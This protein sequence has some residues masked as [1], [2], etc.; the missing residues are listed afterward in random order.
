MKRYL[1]TG[2][3][4][5]IGANFLKYL[6][7]KYEEDIYV[8]VL[9]KLTYAGNLGTIKDEIADSRVRFVKGDIRN[10]ELVANIFAEND[11]DYVVNFAAESHVDRSIAN[12][13]LFLET[14]ILGTQNMLDCARK[15]WYKGK[16][17]EGKP[18]YAEGK[19]FLQVSTD[20]VYG[21]LPLE[22]IIETTQKAGYEGFYSLEWLKRWDVTLEEP[23]IVLAHYV[24]YMRSFA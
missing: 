18:L 11:I 4:G 9:D 12:P 22:Q 21:D 23:G 13:Q 8:V 1:V 7:K 16:D 2:A 17:S 19:K 14:N 15:A 10:A 5:F 6:L 20:E 24:S 3:A